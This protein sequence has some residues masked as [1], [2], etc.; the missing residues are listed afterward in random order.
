MKSVKR[1]IIVD[2][3]RNVKNLCETLYGGFEMSEIYR[4][5]IKLKQEIVRVYGVIRNIRMKEAKNENS[6]NG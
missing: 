2:T 5:N 3:V 6:N 4:E 1:K